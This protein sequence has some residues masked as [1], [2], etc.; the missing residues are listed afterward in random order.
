M[1]IKPIKKQCDSEFT[2]DLS[3]IKQNNNEI[4]NLLRENEKLK[5][6]IRYDSGEFKLPIEK[7]CLI[8]I[9][10]TIITTKFLLLWENKLNDFNLS[11]N[12]KDNISYYLQFQEFM[13][14]IIENI[15]IY[16]PLEK[17]VY[18]YAIINLF[19][20]FECCF[21]DKVKHYR[22]ECH[23]CKKEGLGCLNVINRDIADNFSEALDKCK[24]LHLFE[25]DS[26]T[27]QKLKSFK[28]VRNNIHIYL[29]KKPIYLEEK[30]IRQ[31]YE[32][33]KVFFK[34]ILKKLKDSPLNKLSCKD[35][36]LKIKMAK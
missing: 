23:G 36:I 25:L 21:I 8:H 17:V 22:T 6:I 5:N 10:G 35:R 31:E 14:Y 7:D 3:K 19:S 33:Q 11:K 27:E 26:E 30:L 9:P 15:N 16:G 1:V 34:D 13:D 12:A 2:K 4:S 28:N 32:K 20:I 18:H 29:F 24:E